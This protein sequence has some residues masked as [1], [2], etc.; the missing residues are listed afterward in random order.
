M[1]LAKGVAAWN[2]A[3]ISDAVVTK[4]QMETILQSVLSSSTM[5][6]SLVLSN[7]VQEDESRITKAMFGPLVS[8]VH[9]QKCLDD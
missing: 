8:K 9:P 6:S 4:E 1:V 7:L 2:K 3:A 5:L